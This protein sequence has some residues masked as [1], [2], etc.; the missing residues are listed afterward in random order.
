MEGLIWINENLHGSGFFNHLVKFITA[1]GD[2]AIVWIAIAIVLFCFKR[3]RTC[4]LI[5]LISL[6]IGYLINDFILKNL[7]AR[8]RPFEVNQ[9]IADFIKGIGMD[10]PSGY[11]FPS[12]HSYASFNCAVIL[13]LFNKKMGFF[14]IP[15][16]TMIAL[17]R[18]FLCVHY[19]TDVLV[20]CFLGIL[21]AICVFVV[22]KRIVKARNAR[23]RNYIRW[24][25]K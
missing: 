19:P 10:L 11:S 21:T 20:G 14:T 12:G 5:M 15:L 3:T 25:S 8:A 9:E 4:G 17:S 2:T 18:V 23:K 16:A 7:F 6:A 22:F 1:L 13:L 24:G